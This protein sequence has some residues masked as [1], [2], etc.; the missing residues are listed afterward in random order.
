MEEPVTGGSFTRWSPVPFTAHGTT[1]I[2]SATSIEVLQFSSANMAATCRFVV[3]WMRVSA[4][5]AG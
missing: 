2:A 1:E 4:Q 3:P 5:F